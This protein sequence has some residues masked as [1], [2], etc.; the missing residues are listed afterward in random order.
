MAEQWH[1]RDFR[2][3]PDQVR[4]FAKVVY[5]ASDTLAALRI[6]DVFLAAASACDGTALNTGLVAHADTQRDE[7]HLLTGSLDSFGDA[8]LGAIDAFERQD[9]GA[10]RPSAH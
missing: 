1:Q 10:P 3:D 8:V 4:G 6:H 5:D 9:A 2:L 7:M